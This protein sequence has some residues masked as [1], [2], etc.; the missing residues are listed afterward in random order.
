[1]ALRNCRTVSGVLGPQNEA[2]E[3]V[4]LDA[5]DHDAPIFAQHNDDAERWTFGVEDG[6]ASL[7]KTIEADDVVVLPKVPPW[8]ETVLFGVGIAETDA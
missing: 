1:M 2:K 7:I 8:A 3:H 4:N 5:S 6:S